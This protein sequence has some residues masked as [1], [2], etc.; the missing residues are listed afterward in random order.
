MEIGQVL[1]EWRQSAVKF[2]GHTVITS[3]NQRSKIN[4]RSCIP[5]AYHNKKYT[6]LSGIGWVITYI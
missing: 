6:D 1:A 4:R 3:E 5:H 2:C